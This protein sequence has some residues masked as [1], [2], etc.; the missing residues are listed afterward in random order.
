MKRFYSVITASIILLASM[1]SSSSAFAQ[2]RLQYA[3]YQSYT[4]QQCEPICEEGF[5]RCMTDPSNQQIYGRGVG[6]AN[7]CSMGKSKCMSLCYNRGLP[8]YR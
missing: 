6:P 1:L 2:E 7:F 8:T 4:L 5:K 3:Q